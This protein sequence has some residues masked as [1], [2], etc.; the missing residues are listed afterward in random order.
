MTPNN[1]DT[2]SVNTIIRCGYEFTFNVN[3]LTIRA[4]GSMFNGEEY[5]FVD[6]EIAS[7]TKNQHSLSLHDFAID[8]VNYRVEFEFIN[9]ITG[10]LCCRLY[11]DGK[12]ERVMVATPLK[13]PYV[14][15]LIFV[16]VL[17]GLI[18]NSMYSLNLSGYYFIPVFL[19]GVIADMSYRYKH[20]KITDISV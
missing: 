7:K 9:K 20:I 6:E 14:G 1:I 15:P 19:L 4:G 8:G 10:I 17:A 5:V 11:L 13:S 3:N 2:G 18:V 16:I 12:Q